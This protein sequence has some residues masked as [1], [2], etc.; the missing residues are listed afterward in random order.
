MVSP[1]SISK[2]MGSLPPFPQQ[3][4]SLHCLTSLV[5]LVYPPPPFFTFP[6]QP[7]ILPTISDTRLSILNSLLSLLSRPGFPELHLQFGK[8]PPP[9][10]VSLLANPAPPP[11]RFFGDPACPLR[12]AQ[13]VLNPQGAVP[14][15][16][17]F[18]P[19]PHAV[20]ES[21]YSSLP[22]NWLLFFVLSWEHQL[23]MVQEISNHLEVFS[24]P[25]PH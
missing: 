14:F 8:H 11:S 21:C 3:N 7:T 18:R 10:G 24:G 6:A 5:H 2:S 17:S 23:P 22:P 19:I 20:K 16:P 1:S 4:P 15:H 12:P 13:V 25:S 9:G